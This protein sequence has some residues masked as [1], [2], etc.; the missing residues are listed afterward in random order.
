M[1]C[2]GCPLATAPTNI[3]DRSDA[4][5]SIELPGAGLPGETTD[6][7]VVISN[8]VGEFSRFLAQHQ[9]ADCT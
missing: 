5:A 9:R 3:A 7:M 1:L 8:Q 4:G 2:L 6:Q